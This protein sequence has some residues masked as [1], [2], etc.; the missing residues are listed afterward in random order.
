MPRIK[1]KKRLQLRFLVNTRNTLGVSWPQL[2][3]SLRVHHRSLSDWRRE[4]Y[5]LP[6]KVFN[7]CIKL[8]KSKIKVPPYKVLPD[9]WSVEKAARKGGLIV[10]QKYGGPGI[11]EGKKKEV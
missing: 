7:R 3:K 8:T 6:E 9:F 10:A 5:T 1:F 11:P 2:S 4:K